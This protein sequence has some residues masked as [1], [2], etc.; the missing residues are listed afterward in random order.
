MKPCQ[1]I[2]WFW[3]ETGCPLEKTAGLFAGVDALDVEAER[4]RALR[5]PEVRFRFIQAQRYLRES[6]SMDA[7]AAV[8]SSDYGKS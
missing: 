2:S 1:E 4:K 6:L 5:I 3:R 8:L 7:T